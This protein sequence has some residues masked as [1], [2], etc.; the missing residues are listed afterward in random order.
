MIHSR[1]GA[2]RETDIDRPWVLARFVAVATILVRGDTKL[3]VYPRRHLLEVCA[4]ERISMKEIP[5]AVFAVNEA[6]SAIDHYFTNGSLHGSNNLHP[7]Q[8]Q[9]LCPR[10]PVTPYTGLNMTNAR[11]PNIV[12]IMTDQQR[13][14]FTRAAGFPLDTMPFLDSLGASGVRFERAYTPMPICAPARVSLFTGRFPKAH[15]VRQNSAIPHAVYPADLLDLLRERGYVL[16]LAGKNHSHVK[17]GALDFASLYMHQGGGRSEGKSAQEQAFDSWLTT[18]AQERGSVSLEP[19]PFPVECQLPFRVVRDAI[20]YVDSVVVQ[21]GARDDQLAEAVEPKPFFLWLSFPEPHNPYQV[22]EPYYS[23][24]PENEVPDR[25]A[26]PEALE[27]KTGPMGEKWRWERRLIER[28]NPGYDAHWRRYRANYC[29]MMRLIDDQIRGFVDHLRLRHLLDNTIL[30]LLS[31]HGDYVGDYGLQRKGVG[32]PE[33]LVR[34][35]LIFCGP[36]IQSG[37][38]ER[39]SSVSTVDIVPTLCEALG[40]DVPFGVQGRSLWPLLTG[41]EYP[42]TEFRSIYAESGFGGLHYG[43]HEFPPLHFPYDGRRFDE[44]NSVTQS[45]NT[46]MVR[47]GNC[48]L[49]FDMQGNGELY[50]L[51]TDPA[52][53]VNLYDEPDYR[54][55]R[56]AL[57]E[58]LLRWTIRAE[59][60]LPNAAYLP[61]RAPRNWYTTSSGSGSAA[62]GG[63]I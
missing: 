60:D 58:E 18:L 55:I 48:K 51:E 33:C 9:C 2:F 56:L 61:K 14:D 16:G 13:A 50:D 35:P 41:G 17:P 8:P 37:H 54:E 23:L 49:I 53:L 24:F 47:L 28:V 19:T 15:R 39:K 20:E 6:K 32:L 26:G 12:L 38:V 5:L 4:L 11:Q 44:L 7:L 27:Q 34:I 63:V 36:G 1:C 21:D 29:G 46:K 31:D 59:D 42:S 40:L 43:E 25:A 10:S 30:V 3:H 22:P 57:T 52:E 45:G 62:G